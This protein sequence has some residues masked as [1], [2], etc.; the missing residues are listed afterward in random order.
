MKR[1]PGKRRGRFESQL[2]R[3]KSPEGK[4]KGERKALVRQFREEEK[5]KRGK[6]GGGKPFR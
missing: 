6:K 5:K 2:A 4:E 3:T 1:C